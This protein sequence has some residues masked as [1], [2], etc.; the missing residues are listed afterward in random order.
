MTKMSTSSRQ[1][2]SDAAHGQPAQKTTLAVENRKGNSSPRQ[3][4]WEIVRQRIAQNNATVLDAD[5][6]SEEALQAAWERRKH[7]LAAVVQEEDQGEQIEIAIIRLGRELYGLDVEY[8]FDIRPLEGIT[9]VPR[10]PAWVTGVVNL[11]GQIISVV[12][13]LTFLG[14]PSNR[15]SSDEYYLLMVQIPGMELALLVDEVLSVESLPLRQVQE[16]SG[17]VRGL[18]PEMVRGLVVRQQEQIAGATTNGGENET[19]V[20]LDLPALL[21]DPALIVREEIA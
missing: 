9:H 6:L 11:R 21:S 19:I 8:I 13:L 16:A 18:R 7:Q 3:I 4:D 5:T 17:M 15:H 20:F 12:D 14:L 1:K 10:V 2:T